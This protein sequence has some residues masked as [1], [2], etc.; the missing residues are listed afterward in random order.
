VLVEG[1]TDA[2]RERRSHGEAKYVGSS[3]P[4]AQWPW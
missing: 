2:R 3:S 4:I 1:M